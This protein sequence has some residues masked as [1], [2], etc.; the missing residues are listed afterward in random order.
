MRQPQ[1][2]VPAALNSS[3]PNTAIDSINP[4]T[5]HTS[6]S[7]AIQHGASTCALRIHMRAPGVFELLLLLAMLQASPQV[8]SPAARSGRLSHALVPKLLH[9]W[10]QLLRL[11]IPAL[12]CVFST[13]QA[14]AACL[15]NQ[16]IKKCTICFTLPDPLMDKL[17]DCWSCFQSKSLACASMQRREG[18]KRVSTVRV[19]RESVQRKLASRREARMPALVE[20]ISACT[21]LHRVSHIAACSMLCAFSVC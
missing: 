5:F 14:D 9:T 7:G 17:M 13:P 3:P 21:S 4:T 2:T 8:L 11:V 16:R 18:H 10:L 20:A 15:Y 12:V 6:H 19:I 1:L